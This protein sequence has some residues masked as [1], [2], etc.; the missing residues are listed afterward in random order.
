MRA[1]QVRTLSGKRHDF[2]FAYD[3]TVSDVACA[4]AP[5]LN[6]PPSDVRL[7]QDGRVL[8]PSTPLSAVPL[9]DNSFLICYSASV[10][11]PRRPAV[12]PTSG[13]PRARVREI[14]RHG[15]IVP[16]NFSELIDHICHLQYTREH[17]RAALEFTNYELG[18]AISLLVNGKIIGADGLEHA[19]NEDDLARRRV[20]RSDPKE[21]VAEVNVRVAPRRTGDERKLNDEMRLFTDEQRAAVTRLCARF[22]DRTMV[23]QVFLACDKNEASAQACLESMD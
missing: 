4:S 23:L 19:L 22:P 7:L 6:I 9:Q 1:V 14:D 15:R 20:S 18:S 3:S 17:A 8:D 13:A 10:P 12:A 16:F 21:E 11:A 2:L 5:V